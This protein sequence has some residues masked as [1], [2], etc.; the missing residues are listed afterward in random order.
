MNFLKAG[1]AWL[2]ANKGKISLG[3]SAAV[4]A[5]SVLGY[6]PPGWMVAIL[7]TQGISTSV[8]VGV[9]KLAP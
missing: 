3:V 9:A 1:L 2:D 4:A 8:R 6:T 7:A 5:A